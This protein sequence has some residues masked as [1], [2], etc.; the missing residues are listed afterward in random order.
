[1]DPDSFRLPELQSA[2]ESGVLDKF[3]KDDM[4]SYIHDAVGSWGI[5]VIPD[6]V[7]HSSI[8]FSFQSSGV[9][10]S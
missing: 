2:F 8:S 5:G 4:H 10:L 1:M 7:Y 9:Q 3:R 6:K